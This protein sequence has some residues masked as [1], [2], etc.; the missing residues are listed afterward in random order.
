ML[1][2]LWPA[3]AQSA[4]KRRTRCTST[5]PD[6]ADTL[7]FGESPETRQV[8]LGGRDT[9]RRGAPQMAQGVQVLRAARCQIHGSG[10]AGTQAGGDELGQ[11]FQEELALLLGEA[12]GILGSQHQQ[13]DDLL[14]VERHHRRRGGQHLGARKDQARTGIVER[15]GLDQP[16]SKAVVEGRARRCPW[17][18]CA[19]GHRCR[20]GATSGQ[21]RR[22]RYRRY[23]IPRAAACAA[24]PP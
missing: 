6:R 19:S 2:G 1:V 3:Q 21:A 7:P 20:C 13:A 12:L 4:T 9:V 16:G 8:A 17:R 18:R 5:W 22:E 23:R 14:L 11:H 10:Q 24:A 15:P